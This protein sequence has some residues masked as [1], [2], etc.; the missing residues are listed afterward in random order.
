LQEANRFAYRVG[1]PS[2]GVWHE[3]FNSDAYEGFPNTQAVG[4]GGSV[5]ADAGF[6]YDGLPASAALNLPANGFIIF[7]R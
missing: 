6:G 7:A 3:V 5:V 4:N 1:F 2:G